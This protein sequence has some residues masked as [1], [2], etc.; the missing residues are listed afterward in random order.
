ME[1]SGQL[2]V[3]TEEIPGW[4][5]SLIT[6]WETLRLCGNVVAKKETN[7]ATKD[8]TCWKEVMT[9]PQSRKRDSCLG[10]KY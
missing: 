6:P 8:S 3:A 4:C 10:M 2:S 9:D 7:F 1:D 5:I